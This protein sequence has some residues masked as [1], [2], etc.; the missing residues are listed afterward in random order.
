MQPHGLADV[1]PEQRGEATRT[2]FFVL[3]VDSDRAG[4]AGM[5]RD[6]MTDVVQERRDDERIGRACTLGEIGAL[7]R[8]FKVANRLAGVAFAAACEQDRAQFL[9]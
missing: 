3:I 8:V 5:V 9:R 2:E 6:E 1:R 4:R 7:Q